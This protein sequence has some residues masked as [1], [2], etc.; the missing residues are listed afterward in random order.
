VLPAGLS[1][2]NIGATAIGCGTV[3]AVAPSTI[4]YTNGTLNPNLSPTACNFS[5]N[6]TTSTEGVYTNTTSTISSNEGG[7][8]SSSTA[9]L[10][11]GLPPTIV[12]NF[13]AATVGLN[14]S[15]SLTFTLSNP[16]SIVSTA[17]VGF[18]DTLPAGLVVDTPNGASSTCGGTLTAVA[19]AG[20]IALSGVS[21][22]AGQSCTVSVNVRGTTAGVKN[23]ST[24]V[25]S[26]NLGNGNTT[27]TSITVLSPPTLTTSF[28]AA[29]VALNGTTSLSFTVNNPNAGHT[30]TGIGFSDSLPAGLVVATPNALSGSC[31]GGTI[32]AVAG[33]GTVSLSGASLNASTNCTFSVDVT[34]TTAGTKN[35]VTGNVAST[36]GGTGGTA[37]ASINVLAAPNLSTAFAPGI[38][39]M[40]GTTSLTFTTT[41]PAGNAAALTGVGFTNTLPAGLSVS[42]ASAAICGGTVTLTAPTGISLSGANISANSQCI[43]SV[44]VTGTAAGQYTNTTGAVTSAN[45]GAG[46]TASA[47]LSV[48]GAPTVTA[49]SPNSGP[50]AG[51]TSVTITGTSFTSNATAT[52]GGAACTSLNVVS[53]TSITCVTPAGASGAASVRVTTPGGS[54]PAN[55]LFTY[56]I[57]QTPSF[58]TTAGGGTVSAQIVTGSAGCSFDLANTSAMTPPAYR[59]IAVPYGGLQFRITGCTLG[60]TVRV[61]VTWP[62]LA[63][64]NVLKYGP[65][66]TSGG[67]SDYYAPNNISVVGNTVSY[68]ITDNGLG[69]DTF[70]GPDGVINDPLV[71][72]PLDSVSG[73]PTLSEWAL[74]ALTSLLA[75]IGLLQIRKRQSF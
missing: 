45:G 24:Q 33:S 74:I 60:E 3:S 58:P 75:M 46:N 23:N 51:G 6:I 66:P 17:G 36:N 4:N 67:T 2:G 31:G 55:T 38:I 40:G 54:N 14:D 62:N 44:T 71:V 42:N 69:D 50:T 68:D 12:K 32:T 18:T 48:V 49:I 8:G 15:V 5:I 34:G 7:S 70:T 47:T 22:T 1:V 52:V 16:N 26:T 41:N 56:G 65:T 19:G 73:I 25:T 20:S 39:G 21:L 30:L 28:G 11:V 9:V 29:T 57:R 59:G 53:A 35:N 43:F 61:S 13:G 64:F 27:N 10:T 63:G 72:V 37:S